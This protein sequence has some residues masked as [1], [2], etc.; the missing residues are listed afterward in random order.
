MLKHASFKEEKE[1]RIV[2]SNLRVAP[3][4]QFRANESSVIPY[5]EMALC[6]SE[7]EIEFKRIFIDPATNSQFS[8]EAVSQLLRKNRVPQNAIRL[9]SAPYRSE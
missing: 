7:S 3:D 4:I 8:K 1:W 5:I 9:S 2:S 6:K